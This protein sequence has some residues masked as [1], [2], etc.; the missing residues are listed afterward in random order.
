MFNVW[1]MLLSWVL[2]CTIKL[3]ESMFC[4]LNFHDDCDDCYRLLAANLV[5]VVLV[6]LFFFVV[7][8]CT[9]TAYMVEVVEI[10]ELFDFFTIKD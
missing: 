4:Y 1:L 7:N 10:G 9:R 2:L 8:V 6:K 5:A 3:L